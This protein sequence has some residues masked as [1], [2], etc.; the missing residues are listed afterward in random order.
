[1]SLMISRFS[2]CSFTLVTIHFPL[3]Y[4]FEQREQKRLSARLQADHDLAG[5]GSVSTGNEKEEKTPWLL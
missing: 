5:S 1:M 4:S 2:R 3:L